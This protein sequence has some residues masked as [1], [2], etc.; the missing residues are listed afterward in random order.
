MN[1]KPKIEIT[2]Q[3]PYFHRRVFANL[4]DLILFVL[5][6]FAL[7]LGFRLIVTSTPGYIEAETSLL[8]TMED[9]HLYV[10]EEGKSKDVVS[11]LREEKNNF[12]ASQK[13]RKAIEAIDG[14]LVYL[15]EEAGE[16]AYQEVQATYD[17]YRLDTSLAYEGVP[18]FSKIDGEIVENP[19][20]QADELSYFEKAYS[21]YI[22]NYLQGYLITKIPGYVDKVRYE[23][24]MLIFG[25]ILPS[26]LLAGIL[27][28]LIP[29]LCNP[30]G[31]MT[32]GKMLYHIG[33]ADSRF[34]SVSTPRFLARFAI[35]YFG[36]LVL[37]ILTLG[38]PFLVSVSL[39]A[40]SKNKQG[41]PDYM[42]GIYE[43]DLSHAKLYKSYEE[44]RLEGVSD[45]KDPIDF[46]PINR[47]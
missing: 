27:V 36:E 30:R 22:D 14:F 11:Y 44:I 31:H 25:E 42:L 2:Y 8:K 1:E 7:F 19:S 21:P 39:M 29:P 41:F 28:Y 37:G 23:S 15:K 35:F 18:Y 45:A 6:F 40:F 24:L 10:V 16:N 9:S 3:K 46:K 38:I 26:Y 17:A 32:L 20:C 13:K 4:V 47:H 12:S 33:L 34:L 43:I 5:A